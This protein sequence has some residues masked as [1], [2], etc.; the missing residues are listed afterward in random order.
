MAS[1]GRL[2][3][4][5]ILLTIELLSA[6]ADLEG[7]RI[8]HLYVKNTKVTHGRSFIFNR[9]SSAEGGPINGDN[10]EPQLERFKRASSF[11][12][13]INS[14]VN[15]LNDSH[16]QLMVH[17]AGEGSDVIICLAR[18]PTP[19]RGKPSSVFISYDYGTNFENKTHFFSLQDQSGDY[20]TLDKFYNH[21]K[22]NTHCVFID[23]TNKVIFSTTNHGKYFEMVKLKFHPTD[24]SFNEEEPLTFL[25][26]DKIDPQKKLWVTK[27]FGSTWT[28]VQEYVKAYFWSNLPG[29]KQLLYVEREEPTGSSTVLSSPSYF[30]DEELTKVVLKDVEDFEVREDFMFATKK[31][32]EKNLDLYISHKRKPFVKAV[33]HSETNNLNYHVAEVSD[34]QVFVAVDHDSDGQVNLYVSDRV[35][36]HGMLFTLSLPKI[37]CFFP[38]STWKDSWLNGVTDESFADFHKVEGL[39]GIY[40]A[41]QISNIS[42]TGIRPEH[43][44][45]VITFDMGGE[46]RPLK[47]PKVDNEGQPIKCSMADG[48]S[49]H[50]SQRFNQLYPVTR[51]VPILSSKSAPGLIMA[52]GIIG[53]SLKGHP[54]VFLSRDAGLTWHQ[55]LKDHNF[56]NFGDHGGV[57]V[58]VRYFKSLD[59][60]RELM[61][62]TDEGVTWKSYEF[63]RDDL[64]VYGLMTEPGENTTIFTMFGS[65]K[66]HHQWLI[67]KVD[68][69]NAFSKPC[70]KDDYKYWSPS[71]EDGP[72][73][74]CLLGK[75]EVFLRRMSRSNCYNG[76]DF[77]RPIKTENCECDAEDFQCDDGF[78]RNLEFHQCLRIKSLTF[79]P[80]AVPTSCR[81]GQMY[82]RTKG[83]VKIPGDSCEGGYETRFL[84]DQLPCP[85]KKKKEFILVAQR[86]KIVRIGLE[87]GKLQVL[88]VEKL[89][90][91]IAV[92]F[93]LRNNCVYWADIKDDVIGRQCLSDGKE[94]PEKLV[95]TDLDSIEGMALDWV[96]NLLFFVD[97]MRSTIEVIRIDTNRLG[98]MRRTILNS[99]VLRKPRGIA[100]HPMQ[101]YIFWTDWSPGEASV[102]RANMDGSDVRKLFTVPLVEWPN[103]ITI[104]HIAERIYWVDARKDY[105]SSSDF[106]GK[107]FRKVIS[108]DGRVSHPFAVAVFKDNMYWDD[109][110]QNAIYMADKDLGIGITAIAEKLPGLMDLKIFAESVQEGE[111]PCSRKPSPCPYICVGMPRGGHRCLCPD[112]MVEGPDGGCLCPGGEKPYENGTCPASHACDHAY[113][114]CANGLCVPRLW[115][116]DGDNDC[117]DN[118]DEAGCHQITCPSN[119]IQCTDGKCIPPYW[120]CDFDKDCVDG[121]DEAN[122][123]HVTCNEQQFTCTNGRCIS[124]KWVCDM[125]DDCRDGSDEADCPTASP[126]TCKA[127]EISCGKQNHCIP[128][129]WHCDGESDCADGSDESDCKNNTCQSWQFTC[130]NK[131]C[132]FRAWVCDGQD[133]CQDNS[134]EVNCKHTTNVTTTTPI[135][136]LPTDTCSEW[137]FR[138]SSHK[139]IPYWW[140]C[141]MVNDCGDNS[142]EIG[143]G[144]GQKNTTST[145][146]ATT[147]QKVCHKDQF[148]CLSGECIP[149]S[150]VCDNTR[151]CRDGEDEDNCKDALRCKSG[152]FTCRSDRSCVPISQ[153]CDGISN[154]PDFSDEAGC[155][156]SVMP[157]TASPSSCQRGFFQCDFGS[158]CIPLAKSC[159]GIQDC[160]DGSDELDCSKS[161][162]VYQ[163]LRI[164]VDPHSISPTSLL[165]FWW[166]STPK[167][168]KFEFLPSYSVLDSN[169]WVNHTEWISE[170]E[171]KFDN[172]TPY[173][174]YN[175]TVYVKVKD[176]DEVFPPASYARA[177]TAQDVPSP[178]RN[179][180]V[181]QKSAT[182]VEVSWLPPL[183][184]NGVI[185][186]YVVSMT[187]PIPPLKKHIDHAAHNRVLITS[188]FVGGFN[189]SFWVSAMNTVESNSSNVVIL[190]FDKNAMINAVEDLKVIEKS[191]KSVTLGWKKISNVEGYNVYPIVAA[192]YPKMNKTKTGENQTTVRDLSPGISYTFEVSAFRKN[193]TGPTRTINVQ[194]D[195][196][197]LPSVTNIKAGVLTM[198]R[199]SVKL[200]WDPLKDSRKE[201]W[202]YGVYYAL[203]PKDL[204]EGPKLTTSELSATVK[205]LEACESYVFDVALV[206]PLGRGPLSTQPLNIVTHF[207]V[208]APPKNLKVV[209]DAN[210]ETVMV[211][212]WNSSCPQMTDKIG[213]M[214]TVTELS[215]Q[216]TAHIS[217][218]PSANT[219]LEHRIEGRYGGHY[220]FKVQTLPAA[221]DEK[222]VGLSMPSKPYIYTAPPIFPPHQIQVL[223]ERNGSYIVYWKEDKAVTQQVPDGKYKYKVY[224]SEGHNVDMSTA[225]QYDS[226]GPPFILNNV[227]EGTIYSVAVQLV[228]MDGYHSILSE[229]N[230]LEMPAGTW[231]A[232]LSTGNLVSVVVPVVC[233]VLVLA[234]VIALLALR[235]RRLQR[236]FVSFANSHYDTRSGAATFSGGDGLDEEDSPVIRGFSDD[237]PLVIA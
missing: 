129:T 48:C 151:D 206:G 164:G 148:R 101:G 218:A 145:T 61:Y 126:S 97:G 50:L 103:G 6:V 108:N 120:R 118:S 73:M 156:D 159:D 4:I 20:A 144:D 233:I 157:S 64:R 178:P 70:T 76:R 191:E 26:Y 32:G 223:P 83:Y 56:F 225:K 99:T 92:E 202:V 55:L 39:R 52:T 123:T 128:L 232:V 80:Y 18:D 213:Y 210:N 62:S 77:D 54:G 127:D 195:G 217:L 149:S 150:W 67:V 197:P 198:Q 113:F 44:T 165:L 33:F 171:F 78:E 231:S 42:G 45:T 60:T 176:N 34:G 226:S 7:P 140:K 51:S 214:I 74:S 174:S 88:P 143:C 166:I 107:K 87:D 27:D 93:D 40:I 134:D 2:I 152:Q 82:N 14:V 11:S 132:I 179:V 47:P 135:P 66:G 10:V 9:D 49:L 168:T 35:T 187:P 131:H 84:P 227:K 75:K 65:A 146:A 204:F 138:C 57:L 209:A 53:K 89:K 215:L 142:D 114:K 29:E 219:A 25:A 86:E 196:T 72:K 100:V 162:A 112:S 173:T 31:A 12:D 17:W 221:S 104:D 211:V 189:Y 28:L 224:V 19:V 229:V 184:P 96:S 228:T 130:Q 136:F 235:H 147:P 121:S 236:S 188:E 183:H 5:F 193:F 8:K 24:I 170:L 38:H 190:T 153:V 158:R 58:A 208:Y 41:S 36:E 234:S 194:T 21:P 205:G 85:F 106:D 180:T 95:G 68:L 22:Y 163:V 59:E 177:T 94:L 37:F 3:C 125:E 201:K 111:N 141:D 102:S 161:P 69:R 167:D 1:P 133:D 237:E 71:S 185:T 200:N 192:F 23:S 30:Q 105:I 90:N 116:C 199:T 115:M 109:W 63:Y 16:Q 160:V 155:E 98:W 81:P 124:K 216:R 43:L 172:L 91:V 230:S 220:E 79:D 46:W 181:V 137:M 175:M 182:E 122:C 119:Q 212:S 186:A 222:T 169:K 154:C 110:R 207:D 203:K 117:G 13:G 139:C 15:K